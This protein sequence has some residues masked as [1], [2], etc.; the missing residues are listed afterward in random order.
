MSSAELCR[1]NG[2]VVGTKL[3]TAWLEGNWLDWLVGEPERRARTVQITAIG[4]ECILAR[5]GS[6]Q[7][8]VVHL[9]HG[10]WAEVA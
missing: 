10:D 1:A 8:N 2:W 9:Q 3:E 5:G 6:G 4:E 7:E